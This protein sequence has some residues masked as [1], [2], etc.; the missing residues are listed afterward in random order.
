MWN[1]IEH[2]GPLAA[3]FAASAATSRSPAGV[4]YGGDTILP[5]V[6]DDGSFL[7]SLRWPAGSSTR[8]GPSAGS[9]SSRPARG[10][11]FPELAETKQDSSLHWVVQTFGLS[12]FETDLILRRTSSR[13]LHWTLFEPSHFLGTVDTGAPW[14][15]P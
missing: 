5:R 7:W 10:V 14:G 2:Y 6:G 15:A 12:A 3:S 4:G 8:A 13:D 11:S 9:N 1:A